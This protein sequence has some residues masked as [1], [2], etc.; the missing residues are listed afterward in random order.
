MV[1]VLGKD[2]HDLGDGEWVRITD[3]EGMEG[4]NNIEAKVSTINTLSF[5]LVKVLQ[6]AKDPNEKD[7]EVDFDTSSFSDYVKGGVALQLK[8]PEI[9]KHVS[10]SH[11]TISS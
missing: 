10:K 4:I 11:H 8:K 6:K 5:Q 9:L 1:N 7:Q 2:P 3:V